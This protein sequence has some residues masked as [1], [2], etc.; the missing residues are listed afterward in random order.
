MH[1]CFNKKKDT[2]KVTFIDMRST[3]EVEKREQRGQCGGASHT[4]RVYE[5]NVKIFSQGNIKKL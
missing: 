3:Y 2:T 5:K 4:N 1:C